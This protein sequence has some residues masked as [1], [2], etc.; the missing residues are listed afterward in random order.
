MNF[1]GKILV[2]LIM[3]FSVLFMGLTTVVFSTANNYKAKFDSSQSDLKKAR[4]EASGALAIAE[5]SKNDRD[6]VEK[7]FAEAKTQFENELASNRSRLDTLEAEK[8]DAVTQLEVANQN[9]EIAQS[10]AQ[11]RIR[12]AD[13]IRAAL[14]KTQEDANNLKIEQAQLNTQIRNLERELRTATAQNKQLRTD[15]NAYAAWMRSRGFSGDVAEVRGVTT[16][17]PKLDGTIVQVDSPKGRVVVSL[18]SDDGL[19]PGHELVVYR[20]GGAAGYIGKIRIIEAG[21]DRSSAE[22]VGRTYQ[23]KRIVEGDHVSTTLPR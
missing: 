13:V 1:V 23:G 18:G 11:A 16:A 17:P 14:S 15:V 10:E 8:K 9:L 19:A 22:V 12:E 2:F 4:D 20:T 7:S 3:L 21:A 6:T 5:A